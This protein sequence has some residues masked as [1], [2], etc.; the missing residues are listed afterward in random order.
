M[1]A[2]LSTGSAAPHTRVQEDVPMGSKMKEIEKLYARARA[3]GKGK[4]GA[5]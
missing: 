1:S 3:S 4:G 5:C 2:S